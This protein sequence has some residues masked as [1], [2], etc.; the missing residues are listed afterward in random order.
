MSDIR[1]IEERRQALELATARLVASAAAS[2]PDPLGNDSDS[3]VVLE[4]ESLPAASMCRGTVARSVSDAMVPR[5]FLRRPEVLE[6]VYSVE[7][8]D[9]DQTTT[10]LTTDTQP[11]QQIPPSS[12]AAVQRRDVFARCGGGTRYS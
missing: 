1:D 11:E 2:T 5:G 12:P 4:D 6:T 9:Q 7:E 10:Q 3:A 8:V